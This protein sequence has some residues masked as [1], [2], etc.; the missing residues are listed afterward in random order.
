MTN[1]EY[2]RFVYFDHYY[3][4]MVERKIE[5]KDENKRDYEIAEDWLKTDFRLFKDNNKQHED[6]V[7]I[8]SMFD[9][10]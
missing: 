3:K 1:S 5:K 10:F 4:Y 7:F 9:I 2:E 6:K 8:N